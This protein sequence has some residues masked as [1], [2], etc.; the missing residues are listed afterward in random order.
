LPLDGLQDGR[1]EG[2][3]CG[4]AGGNRHLRHVAP[5][6]GREKAD[7]GGRR[8]AS[9]RSTLVVW[10]ERSGR[11]VKHEG[12]APPAG[13]GHHEAAGG[14]GDHAAKRTSTRWS[15]HVVTR[16]AEDGWKRMFDLD[17]GAARPEAPEAKE[18]CQRSVPA[19]DTAAKR[20]RCMT[21]GTVLRSR[22]EQYGVRPGV[23]SCRRG[24]REI[25]FPGVV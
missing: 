7:E 8:T 16:A 2:R 24:R 23:C 20:G 5:S 4:R 18:P 3:R 15:E 17:T 9:R 1:E 14:R 10:R 21:A 12:W 19:C 13:G 11:Q 25:F 22:A 6:A